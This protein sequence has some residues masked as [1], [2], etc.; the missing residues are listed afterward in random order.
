MKALA[1]RAA[2]ILK[3]WGDPDCMRDELDLISGGELDTV[4]LDILCGM[5]ER[6]L[7]SAVEH[8]HAV[9]Y[10]LGKA[11]WSWTDDNETT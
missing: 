8:P 6:R 5:V 4:Q 2:R 1:D 10:V 7:K 3:V 11:Q 9:D